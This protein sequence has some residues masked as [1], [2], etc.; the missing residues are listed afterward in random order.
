MKS[1]NL[2]QNGFNFRLGN[3]MSSLWNSSWA[4]FGPLAKLVP[5]VDI[6]DSQLCIT[7]VIQNGA[8]NFDCLTLLFGKAT[9]MIAIQLEK[10]AIGSHADS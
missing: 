4:V 5:Y 2:L 7:D 3:D 10:V 1:R 6:H 8:W 9:W